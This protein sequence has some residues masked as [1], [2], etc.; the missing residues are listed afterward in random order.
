MLVVGLGGAGTE[1][2][3]L[4][5]EFGMTVIATRASES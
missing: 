1:I 3:R 5:H 4:A 2:A